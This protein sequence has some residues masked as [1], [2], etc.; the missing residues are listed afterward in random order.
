MKVTDA[1]FWAQQLQVCA[2]AK[3]EYFS[4][5]NVQALRTILDNLQQ[6][7]LEMQT[8]TAISSYFTPL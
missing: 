5:K 1:L 4:P 3:P 6:R 7:R 8:A 2:F